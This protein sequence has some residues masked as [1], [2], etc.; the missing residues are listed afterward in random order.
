MLYA[1][2]FFYFYKMNLNLIPHLLYSAILLS[3]SQ[4]PANTSSESTEVSFSVKANSNESPA[5]ESNAPPPEVLKLVKREVVDKEG[6]GLV[7]STY[8]LHATCTVEDRLYWVYSDATVP[9]RLKAKMQSA[10]N[11]MGIQIFPDVRSSWNSGPS[12]TYG[13][14][15]PR[16][17]ITGM[18]DL[19]AAERKGKNIRYIDEKVLSNQSQNTPTG[20]QHS[21]TGVI[22]VEYDDNGQIFEEEFYARLDVANAVTPTVMGNL[23]SVLWAA[24][25]MF[26]CRAI[27]GNLEECRKIAQT[28]ATSAQITKP[29]FNRLAQV[30]QLLSDQVYA[31]IYQA[32]QISK[33]ISQT[34]DQMLA[35]I[36][37]AYQQSQRSSQRTNDSF[38]DYMR[39][40]DRYSEGGTEI[41][42]PSGYSNAWINDRGEYLLTNTHGYDPTRDFNGTWKQLERN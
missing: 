27:K 6:T 28:V 9:I 36:D 21:Q 24:S 30:I 11:R 35:N 13:Y 25:G 15:P 2:C 12:G 38:S 23:Q 19:I 34:N 40:V 18:K 39:G 22:K 8:L 33:I 4:S 31:Q 32:G 10:D 17:I 1:L 37:H 20:V 16:D 3:C 41:Q 14:A 42:L 29:F 26:A 5:T 7:A